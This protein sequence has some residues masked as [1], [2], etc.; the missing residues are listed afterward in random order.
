MCDCLTIAPAVTMA[1]SASST[2]ACFQNLAVSGFHRALH[3]RVAAAEFVLLTIRIV[4]VFLKSF[5]VYVG[6]PYGI[7]DTAVSNTC[8]L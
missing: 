6:I 2:A 3:R 1:T 4:G 5:S 8:Q 7:Q